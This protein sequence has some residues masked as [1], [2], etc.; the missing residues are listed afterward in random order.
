M[1][2]RP[3]LGARTRLA[4]SLGLLAAVA[5]GLPAS[6]SPCAVT[7]EHRNVWSRAAPAGLVV[8]MQDSDP[9][10]MIGVLADRSVVAS[11]DGG[12]TWAARGTA[13]AAAGSLVL[14]G[15]GVDAAALLPSSGPGLWVTRDSGATWSAASGLP[16]PVRR[17]VASA[18]DRTRVYAVS[19]IAV[20]ATPVPLPVAPG[21]ALY[22]ST[23][24]GAAFQAVPG[25]AGLAVSDVATNPADATQVWLGVAGP[26]GG[27]FLS[28]DGGSTFVNKAAGDVR[29]LATS[30]LAGGGN[31]VVAATSSGFLIS[32]DGGVTVA[33]RSAGTDVAALALEWDH[34]SALMALSGATVVRSPDTGASVKPAAQQLPSGCAPSR[35]RSDRSIPSVFLVDCAD[36]STWRYRSDGADLSAADVPDSGLP[37]A[38]GV[39]STLPATP[40]RELGRFA[41]SASGSR[42]DGSIAYDGTDLY[43][44]DGLPGIV[45]RQSARNGASRPDLQTQVT[46]GIVQLAY[47][48]N[49]NHLFVVDAALAVW[50]VTLP[51]GQATKL[52]TSPAV[53]AP[54]GLSGTSGSMSFDPATDRLLFALDRDSGWVEYDRQGH[55]RASCRGALVGKSYVSDTGVQASPEIAGLVATGDG[56][57]YV[58]TEDDSTVLRMDRSCRLLQ[59]FSHASFSEAGAEND[60]LACD[61]TS[62]PTAAVWLRDAGAEQM[63]AYEVPG[64]YCALPSTLAV[65]APATVAN[66]QPGRVCATLRLRSTGRLLPGLPVDVLVAGRGIG[67]PRTDR[68]GVACQD[69]VPAAGDAGTAP[70]GGGRSASNQPIE[71]VF[72]GTSAYRPSTARGTVLVTSDHPPPPAPPAPPAPPVP[73]P[74]RLLVALPAPPPVQPPQP[75]PNVPQQQPVAQGHPG[76]QPGVAPGGAGALAPEEDAEGAAQSGDVAQF[77]AREQPGLL[78]PAVALPLVAGALMGTVVAR[79]RRASRVRSQWG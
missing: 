63:V 21:T 18:R 14:S 46:K 58:E 1:G 3:T 17:V 10:R 50:D 79:R 9:C 30:R 73:A 23:D 57:V 4:A 11:S 77:T 16:G 51:G 53:N 44:A 60:A 62:F 22:V 24:G 54:P 78:W 15:L 43:Y 29:G 71:A 12:R 70:P 32:R 27:L 13:P 45:H 26:A 67:S 61:T 7:L 37:G 74:A 52:F 39:V 5:V 72:L 36:G 25:A 47:D 55:Q 66:G 2:L 41:I 42:Q 65:T 68:L 64:G 8:G 75:P 33:H 35:L 59:A 48:A 76:A 34:P 69:Y 20:P 38:T 49:R 6:A 19:S 40:M 28:T 56:E 31:E